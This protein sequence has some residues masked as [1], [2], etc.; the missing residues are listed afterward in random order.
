M[1]QEFLKWLSQIPNGY[2]LVGHKDAFYNGQ[3]QVKL[4]I[5]KDS[6]KGS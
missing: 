2:R 3:S 6:L 1:N 5:A 4:F